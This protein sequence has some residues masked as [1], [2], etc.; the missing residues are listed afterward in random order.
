[1]SIKKASGRIFAPEALLAAISKMLLTPKGF[2][3]PRKRD[4]TSIL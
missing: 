1:M 3:V 4:Y 2:V